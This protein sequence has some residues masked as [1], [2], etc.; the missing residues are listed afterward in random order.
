M[1]RYFIYS[2]LHRRCVPDLYLGD[3]TLHKFLIH[4]D[5]ITVTPFN[6]TYVNSLVSVHKHPVPGRF[7]RFFKGPGNVPY[8]SVYLTDSGYGIKAVELL[9]KLTKHV[10]A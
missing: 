2:L 1:V 4:C 6:I 3:K 8:I 10:H 7:P 9:G 5:D